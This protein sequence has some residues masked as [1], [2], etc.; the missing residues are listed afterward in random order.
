MQDYDGE[1]ATVGVCCSGLVVYKDSL[2][3]RRMSWVSVIQVS[4]K[5]CFFNINVRQPEVSHLCFFGRHDI[6]SGAD[7]IAP[8]PHFYKWLGMGGGHRE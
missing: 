7:S 2:R 8:L 4:Y 6:A 5:R 1:P 3:V